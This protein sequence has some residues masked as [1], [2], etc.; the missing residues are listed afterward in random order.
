MNPDELDEEKGG[1]HYGGNIGRCLHFMGQTKGALTC[2]QK[3]VLLLEKSSK[4]VEVLNRGYVRWWIGELLLA[5]GQKRLASIFIEA[6]RRRWEGLA[7][8]LSRHLTD[9]QTKLAD[10]LSPTNQSDQELEAICRGW[11]LGEYLD[12]IRVG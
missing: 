11:I 2:Y 4:R 3:S 6:A 8:A 12:D 1:A 9:L 7:P 5:R 10:S